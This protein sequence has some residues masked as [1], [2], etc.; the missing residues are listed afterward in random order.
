M[1][2][3]CT[4][5]TEFGIAEKLLSRGFFP[6]TPKKPSMA[7]DLNVLDFTRLL[8]LQIAPNMTGYSAAMESFLRDRG[9]QTGTEVSL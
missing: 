1:F 7:V 2:C 4:L 3:A 5:D 6:C 8:F 9:Y